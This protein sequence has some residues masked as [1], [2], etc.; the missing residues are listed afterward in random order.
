MTRELMR[1]Q[2]YAKGAI[3]T[4]AELL[5]IVIEARKSKKAIRLY[6]VEQGGYFGEHALTSRSKIETHAS[7]DFDFITLHTF[8]RS[9]C[10][11]KGWYKT[12]RCLGDLNIVEKNGRHSG[13]NR[14]QMFSNRRCAEEYAAKLAADA[15]YQ[16]A[17]KDFHKRMDGIFGRW[18]V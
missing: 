11:N 17:I 16:Q 3:K 7:T 14:H 5:D 2:G 1:F 4:R 18:M 8:S 10:S 6:S 12:E 13:H 9:R 15:P